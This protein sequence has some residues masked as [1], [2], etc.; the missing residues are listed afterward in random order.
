MHV[1]TDLTG[2]YCIKL[3]M[4]FENYVQSDAE[5]HRPSVTVSYLLYC[6]LVTHI[7]CVQ[8]SNLAELLVH[9]HNMAVRHQPLR[10]AQP[11]YLMAYIV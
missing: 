9:S 3:Q 8:H 2:F 5:C 6:P 10:V 4:E 11:G 7:T 1:S